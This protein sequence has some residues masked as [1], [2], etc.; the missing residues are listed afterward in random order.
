MPNAFI[1]GA[2]LKR[3][4]Q[5]ASKNIEI[6]SKRSA[7]T[8]LTK[9]KMH[10]ASEELELRLG[11][12]LKN[13]GSPFNYLLSE[14]DEIIIPEKTQEVR[15]SGEIQNPIGLAYEKGKGLKYYINRSGGFTE[16][17]RKGKAFV[18]YSNGTT[19]VTHSFLWHKFPLIEPGAQIIIPQKPEKHY[20]DN[21]TKWLAIASTFSTLMIAIITIVKL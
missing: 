17:A 15:I 13:P 4:N 7:D 6:L 12:I 18:I 9:L 21:T 10:I 3:S 14:G 19:Q 16:K 8:L 2:R 11:T 5:Q 1:E 20:T